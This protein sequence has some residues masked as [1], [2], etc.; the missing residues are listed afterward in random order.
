VHTYFHLASFAVTDLFILSFISW[1]ITIIGTASF[2]FVPKHPLGWMFAIVAQLLYIPYSAI[3]HQWGFLAH[4]ICFSSAFMYNFIYDERHPR[5]QKAIA[6][7]K[8]KP[9]SHAMV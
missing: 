3:N 6:E 5:V 8:R 7:G 9:R 2:W 1:A 4:A